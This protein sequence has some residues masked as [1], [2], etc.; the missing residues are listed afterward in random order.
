MINLVLQKKIK[1]LL[2]CWFAVFTDTFNLS[3]INNLMEFAIDHLI[4]LWYLQPG[5]SD[6]PHQCLIKR[7]KKTS[8]FHLY[9][10]LS[11][12]E[13][14]FYSCFSQFHP[15]KSSLQKLFYYWYTNFDLN[16]T[17]AKVRRGT[18]LCQPFK[19]TF[20]RGLSDLF[21]VIEFT[22]DLTRR[23]WETPQF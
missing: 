12:C 4:V 11:P 13:F 16:V 17:K 21:L 19:L 9:L 23:I 10:A 22:V 3:V 5:P 7:N 18:F 1:V 20:I 8:T 6:F 15:L 14:F 2:I